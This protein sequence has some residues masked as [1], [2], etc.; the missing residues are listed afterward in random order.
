MHNI[1]RHR[2]AQGLRGPFGQ[3]KNLRLPLRLGLRTDVPESRPRN[4]PNLRASWGPWAALN[5]W[6]WYSSVRP[7]AGDLVASLEQMRVPLGACLAHAKADRRTRRVDANWKL[8]IKLPGVLP[9]RH[10][11]PG[12]RPSARSRTGGKVRA[13]GGPYA[14]VGIP[15]IGQTHKI[16]LDADEFATCATPCATVEGMNGR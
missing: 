4:P 2:G 3:S 14:G 13:G 11:P 5:I 12:L 10:Q 7:N 9:L 6:A 8:A 16:Y 15:G 1:C